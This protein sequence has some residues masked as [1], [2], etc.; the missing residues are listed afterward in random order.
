MSLA[1]ES[2]WAELQVLLVS[3]A[4]GPLDTKDCFLPGGTWCWQ[5]RPLLTETDCG[6][7]GRE[8]TV[9]AALAVLDPELFGAGDPVCW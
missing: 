4:A 1:S 2:R 5:A 7:A 3:A 8:M 6:W 9:D